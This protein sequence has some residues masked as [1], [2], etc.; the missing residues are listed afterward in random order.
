MFTIKWSVIRKK[1]FQSN[2][3]SFNYKS[4]LKTTL[5]YKRT[6]LSAEWKTVANTVIETT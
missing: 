1:V 2:V 5:K 3:L 4:F 6:D